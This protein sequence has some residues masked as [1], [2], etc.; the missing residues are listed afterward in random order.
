MISHAN[1]LAARPHVR[2]RDEFGE[3][4][5]I[6]MFLPLAHS[7]ARVTQMVALDSAPT[8]A[9]WQ[10]DPALLLD[11]VREAQPTHFPS[12]PRVFEKIHTKATGGAEEI[13]PRQ[14]RAV[15]L[16]ARR[17]GASVARPSAAGGG[18]GALLRGS[19]R[20]GRPAR[21][22]E[23]PRAVRRPDLRMAMT[24]AAPIGDRGARVLRCLRRADPRG[25]RHD[26]RPVPARRSTGST[27]CASAPSADRCRAPRWRSAEDGEILMRGPHVFSGYYRDDAATRET[28][29]GDWLRSGDLGEIDE[30]GFLRITGRKKELIITSS[31]K[32][33]SAVEH[34]GARCASRA[35]SRRRSSTA[36]TIPTSSHCSRSTPRRR[37]AL[38]AKLGVRARRRR[39]GRRI[40]ACGPRSRGGRRGERELRADRADQALCPARPRS[41]ASRRRADP[42][43]QDQAGGRSTTATGRRFD[44]LYAG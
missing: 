18:P 25:L 1:F 26:A 42:D 6:F 35:G 24:G 8:L 23:G 9:F 17:P 5:V 3:S 34:R 43:A 10:G 22:V 30:N 16:G 27:R 12:V 15:R 37:P 21:A 32:N 14:A 38:A 33:I 44:G 4:P 41:D 28:F 29:D 20:A 19:P 2:G 11:D 36:T 40:C 39:D 7:L 31:G 13:E